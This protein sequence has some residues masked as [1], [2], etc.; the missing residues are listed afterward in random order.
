MTEK[1]EST[2]VQTE[3]RWSALVSLLSALASVLLSP[4]VLDIEYG[5][6][7]ALVAFTL[8]GL[9]YVW[10]AWV[11]RTASRVLVSFVVVCAGGAWG[12]FMY[13]SARPQ[14]EIIA[15]DTLASDKNAYELT[16]QLIWNR[17][18]LD[19]YGVGITFPLEIVPKYGGQQGFGSVVALISGDGKETFERELWPDFGSESGTQQIHLTLSELVQASGLRENSNPPTNR[20]RPGDPFF[21]Q[22][23]LIVR[24]VRA[25]DK[26]H[27]WATEEITIRNTPWELRSALVLRDGRRAADVYFRNLGGA[28]WFTVRYRL[29]R[30]EKEIGSSDLPEVSG[31]TSIATW[32]E[33]DELVYLEKGQFFTD[34]VFL[35]NQLAQGRYLLEAYAVKKQDYVQFADPDTTWRNLNSMNTP[36]WFGEYPSNMHVFVVTTP[37]FPIDAT[38]QAE[39]ERLR[40]EQGVDLGIALE[41]AEEVTSATGTVGLRQVFEEG[42]IYV[43]DSRAYALYGPILD[44][45][46]ELG[47]VEHELLGFPISPIQSVTSSSGAE[48]TRIEFEGDHYWPSAIYAS[49][50]VVAATWG[51]IGQTYLEDNG[52]HGGWM[53]FPLADARGHSDSVIQM[54]EMG[55]IVWYYPYVE[56]ERDW[57][58]PPVAYPYITSR[59]ELTADSTLFDV[60]ADQLWQDTGVQV[61]PGDR[62]TIIQVGGEWTNQPSAEPFDANGNRGS[63]FREDRI[64]P[65]A[66]GGALIGKVGEDDENALLVGRWSIITTSDED[67]LYLAMN[68]SYYG[69]NSGFITVQIIVEHSRPD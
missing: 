53:G 67:Q 45:Y 40:D 64:L 30:L 23:K 29:V 65:L 13:C 32:N 2:L 47:G 21:Q 19:E 58:R 34:T 68:D 59:G 9:W 44:H 3:R 26:E 43:H 46:R 48:G 51:S 15:L 25:A 7:V 57:S 52:G 6:Y 38:I 11:T 12:Y 50:E 33:P 5:P 28:G 49:G 56:G 61:K 31:T 1:K 66:L 24:V 18:N 14:F 35:T 42:E 69:D 16:D 10:K 27:P 55:Y 62:V 60:H 36:W 39:W 4:F 8:F 17:D 20:F 63:G 37:E 22:A 54:F 41:P